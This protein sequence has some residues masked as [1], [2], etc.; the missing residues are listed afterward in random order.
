MLPRT[1][2]DPRW[3]GWHL[4]GQLLLF[5][6]VTGLNQLIRSERTAHLTQ[7]APR[8]LQISMTNDCNR[9]CPFCYRPRDA[10]SEWTLD[11]LLE[12]AR[13]A[14]DWGALELAFGGGEPLVV[15][16]FAD[17][18]RAVWRETPLCP[19]FTT[20]GTLLT[21]RLLREIRGC[22]GQI[23]LSLYDDLDWQEMVDLLVRERAS[24]G[25]NYLVT[26]ERVRSLEVDVWALHRRGVNDIL[27]L[28]YRGCDPALHLSEVECRQLDRSLARL[29][30]LLGRRMSLKVDV[31]WGSRLVRTPQLLASDDCGAGRVFVSLTS[32][33]RLL[34]CSFQSHGRGIRF[35]S[36]H[37]LPALYR[38][39]MRDRD[40]VEEP[41]CARVPGFGL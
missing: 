36:V 28:S 26:P 32:D 2:L 39:H 37:D 15:A 35:E 22:Y 29:H 24:F 23:Q 19:H 7:A 34:P 13:V 14:A 9:D 6:R 25:I 10:R 17:F 5:D 40:P 30:E 27:F 41:G 33:R 16:G 18:L 4:D 21:S 12:L 11:D 20:N 8:T 31:C 1:D 38:E 3:R